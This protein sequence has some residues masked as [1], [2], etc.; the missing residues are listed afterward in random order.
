MNTTTTNII[1]LKD[2]INEETNNGPKFINGLADKGEVISLVGPSDTGKSM[3][4]RQLSIDVINGE[5]KFLS[6]ELNPEHKKV[7]Y[8]SSEDNKE[9]TKEIFLRMLQ[10][11]ISNSR[12]LYFDFNSYNPLMTLKEFL[13]LINC[14]LVVI[15]C[16]SDYFT[17]DI[18]RSTDIRSFLLPYKRLASEF[19][20]LI[21]F[22]HHTGK[23]AEKRA[24]DKNSI[25]GSQAIEG[26]MRLVL[27]LRNHPTETGHKC[28]TI[29][30]GNYISSELKQK[31]KLLRFS[32]QSLKFDDV[33]KNVGFSELIADDFEVIEYE[34]F[35]RVSYM[36]NSGLSYDQIAEKIGVSSRG[37]ISKVLKKGKIKGWDRIIREDEESNL[38]G[39]PT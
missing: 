22:L 26:A 30:K 29:L 5:N 32:E 6:Y 17:S 13:P 21:I 33:F 39:I 18:N 2:I 3:I 24:P 14:D 1:S 34:T 35:K 25:L 19:N 23:N 9:K 10:G 7:I 31:A 27:E 38:D 28:L 15:D 36:Y 12:N 16:F 4:L 37:T 11:D 8:F 20:C